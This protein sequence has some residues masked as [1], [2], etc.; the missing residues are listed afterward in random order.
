M[1]GEV[2]ADIMV[3]VALDLNERDLQKAYQ[4]VIR[5]YIQVL[6][7]EGAEIYEDFNSGYDVI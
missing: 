3:M 2:R 1:I 5:W 6:S 7:S 4:G